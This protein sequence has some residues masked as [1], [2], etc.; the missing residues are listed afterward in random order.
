MDVTCRKSKIA[1][2]IFLT[3]VEPQMVIVALVINPFGKKF[4]R[5]A[6]KKIKSLISEIKIMTKIQT[7]R[8]FIRY[9]R[10]VLSL[11]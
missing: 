6:R 2:N 11:S 8:T 5:N 4:L 1:A 7:F 9:S 10:S 3:Y